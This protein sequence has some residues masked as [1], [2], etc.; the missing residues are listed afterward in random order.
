MALRT[1]TLLAFLCMLTHWELQ[2][3]DQQTYFR[4]GLRE[5]EQSKY[6]LAIVQFDKCL[7]LDP[8]N[9]AAYFHRG[10]CYLMLGKAS[11][12][13][14]DFNKTLS[15]DTAMY[16]TY[17]N[18]AL[19]HQALRNYTFAEGDFLLYIERKRSDIKALKN[20]AILMEQMGELQ[21][22]INYYTR[23]L[24]RDKTNTE[25]LKNRALAYAGLDSTKLAIAD[26]EACQRLNPAD[27]TVWLLKGNIYY[28]AH[29]YG[30][31][32]DIY[33]LILLNE[34]GNKAALLDRA[35]AYSADLQYE[36]ALDDYQKLGKK[37][38][39]NPELHFNIA[40]CQLQLNRYQEAVNSFTIAMNDGYSDLGQLLTLRGVAYNNLKLQ[41]EACSDW[42]KAIDLQ[43]AEAAK[44]KT[45]Y[46]K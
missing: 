2:A 21:S 16:E 23:Y 18:R 33:N 32:I 41:M 14:V 8:K 4:N 3:Q 19:A 12:A 34:P 27:T 24:E 45:N 37:D 20:L 35:D 6:Q 43:Y 26:L 36:A 38:L 22:A 29:E 30:H 10:T 7:T 46:C 1:F 13:L 31:A 15:I 25:V 9:A 5:L 42:Q 44:Y 28:D 17:Y 11:I 40:F 39:N